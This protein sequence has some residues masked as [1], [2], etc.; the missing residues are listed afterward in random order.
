[1]LICHF[2]SP[3]P[4]LLEKERKRTPGHP[5]FRL[6][7][8]RSERT[9]IHRSCLNNRDET[10]TSVIS[11]GLCQSV[12]PPVVSLSDLR[13]LFEFLLRIVLRFIARPFHI[14][15]CCFSPGAFDD[16]SAA[17]SS[18]FALSKHGSYPCVGHNGLPATAT[19]HDSDNFR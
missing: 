7:L 3:F 2:G 4:F 9:I 6:A 15:T 13:A 16:T 19:F 12:A 1:M 17:S 8:S 5:A 10:T 14:T 18:V 11:L